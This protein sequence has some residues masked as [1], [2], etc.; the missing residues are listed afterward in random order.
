MKNTNELKFLTTLRKVLIASLRFTLRIFVR[1]LD[2]SIKT[3]E[4]EPTLHERTCGQK[5]I[6]SDKYFIPN[7][8]KNK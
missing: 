2:D 5:L 4:Y 8:K 3:K 7:P 1:I 6:L